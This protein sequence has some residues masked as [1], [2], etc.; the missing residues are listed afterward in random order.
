M[1]GTKTGRSSSPPPQVLSL[2]ASMQPRDVFGGGALGGNRLVLYDDEPLV[3]DAW[4]VEDYHLETPR[5][6]NAKGVRG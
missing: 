4:N 2:Q 6:L 3:Y 5:T 1:S